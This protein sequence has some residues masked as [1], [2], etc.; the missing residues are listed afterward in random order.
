MLTY[1]CFTR[2]IIFERP[3]HPYPLV[4]Q[5]ENKDATVSRNAMYI[6]MYAPGILFIW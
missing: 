3:L 5:E 2:V 6:R 1:Y 4:A